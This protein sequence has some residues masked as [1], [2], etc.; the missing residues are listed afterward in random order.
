M[1]RKSLNYGNLI[2]VV[3]LFIT[4]NAQA[5]VDSV[6]LMPS[7]AEDL[8]HPAEQQKLLD[9]KTA[10]AK[11]KKAKSSSN[12]LGMFKLLIPDTLR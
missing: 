3:L 6:A 12:Y 10:Q 9:T 4:I 11:D 8:K 5:D 2:F 1:G 7:G